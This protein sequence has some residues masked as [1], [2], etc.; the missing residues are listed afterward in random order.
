MQSSRFELK[1]LIT[2]ACARNIRD[3]VR[4]HLELDEHADPTRLHSAYPISSLYLDTNS[5]ELYEQTCRGL[6]NRFKLR[7]RFYDDLHDSPVFLEIKSRQTDVIR[8]QRACMSREG[9]RLL[10]E[11][12]LP[13]NEHLMSANG[14]LVANAAALQ[15]F[16]GLCRSIGADGVVYVSYLREAYVSPESDQIRV[17]FD[18]ELTSAPFDSNMGLAMP[19]RP[20]P[21]KLDRVILEL[22]FTDRF[23]HWMHDLVQTFNLSRC[24]VPKYCHC[25]ETLGFEPGQWRFT[26]RG[27]A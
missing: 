25:I 20:S 13:G 8:K 14:S 19:R 16:H 17:T 21:V 23:P 26:A 7:I 9:A 27:I 10:L 12:G 24:S 3:F 22:K 1:Y 5:L 4:S 6:K 15:Q 18:R 2:E 11:G